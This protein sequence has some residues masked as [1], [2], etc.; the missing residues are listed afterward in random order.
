MS[1]AT[2]GTAEIV[3]NQT[4]AQC[5]FEGG[6][7]PDR[8]KRFVAKHDWLHWERLT[9]ERTGRLKRYV[10]IEDYEKIENE[11]DMI[12]TRLAKFN[13]ECIDEGMIMFYKYDYEKYVYGRE[14]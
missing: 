10:I 4:K 9:N 12:E 13:R 14:D 2:A 3:L 5:G 1:L 7:T 6:V 8:V 11:D